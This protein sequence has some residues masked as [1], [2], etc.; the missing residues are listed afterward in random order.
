[1]KI[2]LIIFLCIIAYII[3][4]I[5]VAIVDAKI[6]GYIE[7]GNPHQYSNVCTGLFW[8]L[9]IP[10]FIVMAIYKI[11]DNIVKNA[12]R[13]NNSDCPNRRC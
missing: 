5:F 1:M 2:L 6:Y 7:V 8:P 13:K 3:I 9:T 12:A 10:I 11:I 4:S